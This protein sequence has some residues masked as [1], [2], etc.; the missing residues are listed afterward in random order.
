MKNK[1]IWTILIIFLIAFFFLFLA[2][3]PEDTWICTEIGWIEHGKPSAPKPIIPCGKTEEEQVV[4][5][6]LKKN[7]SNISTEK[8]VLGGKFYITKIEWLKNNTGIVEYEDGHIA[9]K[10]SF[11]YKI[12]KNE[13]ED[14]YLISITNFKII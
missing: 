10:A 12:V 13:N 6:Y 4:E 7:I 3:S 5:N 8:E 2:R 14:N 1:V 9:L 11:E